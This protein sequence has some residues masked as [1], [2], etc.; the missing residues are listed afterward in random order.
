ML[1][2]VGLIGIALSTNF[3][4]SGE[5]RLR[6]R[7]REEA[8]LLE[9]LD[10]GLA[11]HARFKAYVD[12]QLM[13]YMFRSRG[14]DVARTPIVL[15][16]LAFVL[17]LGIAFAIGHGVPEDE[18]FDFTQSRVTLGW[19]FTAG[20]VLFGVQ[21]NV[22]MFRLLAKQLRG[23]ELKLI[24]LRASKGQITTGEKSTAPDATLREDSPGS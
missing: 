22:G 1:A 12:E 20:A 7:L 8:E 4:A 13:L 5:T 21:F 16:G 10:T 17:F 14:G 15:F 18:M 9:H 11:E 19:V 6:H 3:L 23:I 2:V 24:R